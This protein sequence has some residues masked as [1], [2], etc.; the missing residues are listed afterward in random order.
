MGHTYNFSQDQMVLSG[1]RMWENT[2]RSNMNT[3]TY[4]TDVIISVVAVYS[5]CYDKA[6]DQQYC[7][8]RG[9][10]LFVRYLPVGYKVTILFSENPSSDTIFFP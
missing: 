2:R 10:L 8:G 9:W 5:G 7:I 3:G 6:G 1:I 4:H